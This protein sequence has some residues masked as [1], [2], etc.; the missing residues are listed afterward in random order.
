MLVYS[1][2]VVTAPE[3]FAQRTNAEKTKPKIACR[4]SYIPVRSIEAFNFEALISFCS[5]PLC[6]FPIPL[7][8][9]YIEQLFGG[10]QNR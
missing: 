4:F 6:C 5:I 3:S 1:K 9:N 10:A 7:F 8:A 2:C